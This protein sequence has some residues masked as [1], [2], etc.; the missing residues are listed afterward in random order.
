QNHLKYGAQ[1][2]VLRLIPGLEK[3]E[4]VRFGQIHRNTFICAPAILNATLRMREEPRMLFAGQISG[5]EGYIEAIATGLMAGV[6]AANIA[7][8]IEPEPPPRSTAMGSLIHYVSEAPVKNFQ[9]MNITFA[10]LPALAEADRRH[11]R[12]KADRRRLQVELALK[13]FEVW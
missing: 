2:A 9:P 3:A 1:K 6:H 11:L 5:V 13:D 10:L 12:H 8:G 4:F 7:K